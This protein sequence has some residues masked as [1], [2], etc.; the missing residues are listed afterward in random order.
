MDLNSSKISKSKLNNPLLITT[1][2]EASIYLAK[3]NKLMTPLVEKYGLCE[4]KWRQDR[5]SR[6]AALVETICFQQLAGNAA[7]T[8]H[9]RVVSVVG[10]KIT[11]ESIANASDQ[12]L[13]SAG[14][15]ASKVNSIRS[16]TEHVATG[17]LKLSQVS[18][19]T[20]DE[21]VE[22]LIQVKGIGPWSAHMFLM[23]RLQRLDIWPT[24]DYGVRV[25][26]SKILRK[27][28]VVSE[29]ECIPLGDSC[30]P[31]RSVLAWYCWKRA[32]D[33]K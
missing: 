15:S 29:K 3:T 9:N 16:L 5:H 32:D 1:P 27:K 2:V 30:A 14:L 31:F 24:G 23:E 6:Y 25:G 28:E 8:I 21:V 13:K 7:R 12:D 26:I 10:G 19:M 22:H 33:G 4:L 17:K 11:V 18:K 20:N